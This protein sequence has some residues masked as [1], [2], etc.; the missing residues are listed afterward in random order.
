[1]SNG[2]VPPFGPI[3]GPIHQY[4]CTMDQASNWLPKPPVPPRIGYHVLMNKTTSTMTKPMG[5][6]FTALSADLQADIIEMVNEAGY[7]LDDI[8]DFVEVHGAEAYASGHYITWCQLEEQIGAP[9]DA[10]EAFVEEF[11][12]DALD[13]FEDAYRGEY[14][15]EAEFA[16][17]Y[18]DE[19]Y[20]LNVPEWVVIDWQATWDTNLQYD[21][22]YTNG[23]VFNSHN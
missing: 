15:S 6:W 8:R 18:T 22:V 14:D 17:Q 19:C 16:E 4:I 12:I 7:P 10:I 20:T 3:H 11:G 1:M 23:F 13:A 21:F 5:E 9:T 2:R